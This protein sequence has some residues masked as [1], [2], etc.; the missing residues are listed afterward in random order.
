[1]FLSATIIRFI[2]TKACWNRMHCNPHNHDYLSVESFINT[3]FKYVLATH[4]FQLRSSLSRFESGVPSTVSKKSKSLGMHRSNMQVAVLNIAP[5]GRLFKT[6]TTPLFV[7][8]IVNTY[9][10]SK[11][12]QSKYYENIFNANP[13]ANI[14]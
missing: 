12:S 4:E 10:L 7:P 14:R 8:S 3:S 11:Q 5:F 13:I 2:T 6:D 1:M 9:A